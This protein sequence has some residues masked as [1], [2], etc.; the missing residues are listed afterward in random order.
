MATNLAKYKIAKRILFLTIFSYC[1]AQP[2]L[3]ELKRRSIDDAKRAGVADP[4][5][6]GKQRPHCR[7]GHWQ[8]YW[9]GKGRTEARP[10]FVHP[11]LVNATDIGDVEIHYKVK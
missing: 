4:E 8:I 6:R 7:P 11:Y 5:L 9:V 10:T 2:S 3:P 1:N